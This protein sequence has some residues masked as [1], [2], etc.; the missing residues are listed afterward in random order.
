MEVRVSFT[1]LQLYRRKKSP[2]Y[3]LN[4][5]LGGAQSRSDSYE[6][7]ENNLNLPLIEYR[8]SS[9]SPLLYR[10]SYPGSPTAVYI[11]IL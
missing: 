7:E 8:Q 2:W 9:R 1:P 11:P 4:M 10:L 6:D 3:T 5:R